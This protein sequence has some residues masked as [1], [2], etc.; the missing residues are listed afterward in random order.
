MANPVIVDFFGA[1]AQLLTSGTVGSETAT[2]GDPILCIKFS[3]LASASL[4]T[5]TTDPIK[6]FASLLLKIKG[7]LA[8]NSG[9][10]DLPLEISDPTT[11]F[12]LVGTTSTIYY[13]WSVTV[14]TPNTVP[15]T[16]DPDDILV[17]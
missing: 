5:V 8:S 14:H 6:W 4:N 7:W 10:G 16:L 2:S 11:G 17:L 15:N 3:D 9:A 12:G 1:N 13:D